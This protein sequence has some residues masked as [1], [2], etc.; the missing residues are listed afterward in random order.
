MLVE[1][2]IISATELKPYI[3]W[4]NVK[5]FSTMGYVLFSTC[6]SPNGSI[7]MFYN[8]FV[9]IFIFHLNMM[10]VL[11]VKQIVEEKQK[12]INRNVTKHESVYGNYILFLIAQQ[13][14]LSYIV[15][16]T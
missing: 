7:I 3:V 10:S 13:K 15:W 9:L 5:S 14:Q 2:N 8:N 1:Y 4:T 6:L 16:I 11:F 12:S